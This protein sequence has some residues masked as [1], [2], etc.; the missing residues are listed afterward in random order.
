M[1]KNI[2]LFLNIFILSVLI[3]TFNSCKEDELL[4]I[5][6]VVMT[7]ENPSELVEGIPLTRDQ[8]NATANVPGTMVFTPALGEILPL[9]DNQ[10]LKAEFTPQDTKNYSSMSKTV[11]INIVDKYTPVI[12]WEDPAV[13]LENTK[14]SEK[15]LNA[16]AVYSDTSSIELEGT[17]VYT[18]ALG[19]VLPLGTHE[20][21]VD[22]TP[23]VPTHKAT[24]KTVNITVTDVLPLS[25]VPNSAIHTDLL[26]FEFELSGNIASLG[27]NP[28][29]GF[30]VHV[31]NSSKFVDND[32]DITEVTFDAANANIL[33]FTIAEEIYADDM[34]T[35]SYNDENEENTILSVDGLPI[36]SFEAEKVAIPVTGDNILAGNDWAGFE[37]DADPNSA[38]AAGYWVGAALPWQRTT[39]MAASGVASMKYTGGFDV[40]TLY[41]MKFGAN[42]DIQP[43]A[44]EVSHKI[45]IEA[46]SDLKTLRTDIAREDNEWATDVQALW[47]VENIKR[48][49]WVT[50]KQVVNMPYAYKE[51]DKKIRYS[52]YVE[53]SNNADVTGD[54]TFYLDDMSLRKVDVPVRP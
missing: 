33:Q 17:Y 2:I 10:V 24:S 9:G 36:L 23:S 20:L 13:L 16:I 45:Y 29:A 5:K 52:Y 41:G 19:T 1:K 38:G 47:D 15:Q 14:L 34:I 7:W 27:E 4:L 46:G 11:T 50:I 32:I 53:V 37:A 49:E 12:I 31:T 43:G 21:K 30:T 40:K 35:I 51:V 44:F 8:L 26:A 28:K 39:D 3:T 54:Q 22:F 18:P 42:V 25:I 6:E 48:G